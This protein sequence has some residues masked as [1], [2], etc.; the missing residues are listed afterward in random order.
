MAKSHLLADVVTIIGTEDIDFW[1]I[2]RSP[3]FAKD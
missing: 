3:Y 2:D 1:E